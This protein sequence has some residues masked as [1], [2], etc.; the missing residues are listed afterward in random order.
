M[1]FRQLSLD[2]GHELDRFFARV[3]RL[4]RLVGGEVGVSFTDRKRHLWSDLP[5]ALFDLHL[6]APER[7]QLG[8]HRPELCMNLVQQGE[9]GD[10]VV[11]LATDA[12]CKVGFGALAE[13][14]HSAQLGAQL[15]FQLDHVGDF[16]CP[17]RCQW[18]VHFLQGRQR[19]LDVAVLFQE[20]QTTAPFNEKP[21]SRL[22]GL[23]R[24]LLLLFFMLFGELLLFLPALLHEGL[25]LSDLRLI[26]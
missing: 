16:R 20:L 13:E 23:N 12:H 21:L 25:Q 14:L 22:L 10:D 19:Q 8:T 3:L 9:N 5:K 11:D 1:V 17:T 15:L 2:K 24:E 6:E 7:G 26:L 18:A 4:L